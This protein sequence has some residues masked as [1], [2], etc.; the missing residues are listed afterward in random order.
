IE[1]VLLLDRQPAWDADLLAGNRQQVLHGR[2]AGAPRLFIALNPGRTTT[3]LGGGANAQRLVAE[4]IT[5]PDAVRQRMV[6][7]RGEQLLLDLPGQ[8]LEW[9]IFG[10]TLGQQETWDGHIAHECVPGCGM[11][12]LDVDE[13]CAP[14]PEH[15]RLNPPFMV[16]RAPEQLEQVLP[17]G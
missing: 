8:L 14:T 11:G 13:A 12:S 15:R 2:F 17:G 9:G 7:E 3:D 1:Q 6:P 5:V 10:H 4:L 16:A